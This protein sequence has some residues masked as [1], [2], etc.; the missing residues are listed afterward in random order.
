MSDK[1][2]SSLVVTI[3]S[4][5]AS[6]ASFGNQLV[7]A[8]L[9]GAAVRLDV[10]LIATSVPFLAMGVMGG[11]FSYAVVPVLVHWR[12][13]S[14]DYPLLAGMLLSVLL[15][16]SILVLSF[17]IWLS[18]LII[19]QMAPTL[20]EALFSEAVLIIRLDW[21]VFG[22]AGVVSYLTA[23]QNAAHKFV[24]P[25]LVTGLPHLAMIGLSVMLGHQLGPL[26]LILGMLVGYL[27]SILCLY[28]GVRHDIR[29]ASR[30]LAYW[31]KTGVVLRP[32][33]LILVSMLC[34]TI[35]GTVDAVWASRLGPSTV[36]YLGY[37]QR[38]LI[39]LG[40]TVILAPITVLLPHLS[41][42]AARKQNDRVRADTQVA[43]RMVLAF[44]ALVAV[45]FS[46]LSV[47]L[48][49]VLFERGAFDRTATLGVASIL[50]GMFLGMVAMVCV[51]LLFRSFYAQGDVVG[52]ALIGGIGAVLYAGLSGIFSQWLGLMGIVVAYI[53][54]WWVLFGGSV[55]RLWRG[56]WWE[57]AT[58]G[59]LKFVGQLSI[60]LGVAG[61][62]TWASDSLW[63]QFGMETGWLALNVR[64]AF[65][66]GLGMLGFLA[67]A[68]WG[69]KLQ[70]VT[71]VLELLP[72]RS[73]VRNLQ[74]AVAWARMDSHEK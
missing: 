37:A 20:P 9:F 67:V 50:P 29:L 48:V 72:F 70:E 17:A 53:V 65:S 55:Y 31:R 69:F 62:L 36:S 28:P 43:L 13:G 45:I 68:A 40:N 34:F 47:S 5:V 19:Q 49:R 57:V 71:R 12:T 44:A 23:V 42:L 51:A 54:T 58:S 60:A 2:R 30:A 39:A 33:P 3:L 73:L 61:I 27:A 14:E 11:L 18:P 46:L 25:V 41:E 63:F 32:M 7:I 26:S 35:Y 16:L 1:L 4:L 8:A 38:L 22:A 21:I 24:I 56:H 10:Y 15:G 66:A 52:A 59:N 64:L 6:F 74:Q